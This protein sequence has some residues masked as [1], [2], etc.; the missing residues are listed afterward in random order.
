MEGYEGFSS[1]ILLGKRQRG[2][3]KMRAD[4]PHKMD[5]EGH[6]LALSK[7]SGQSTPCAASAAPRARLPKDARNYLET[8]FE[9]IGLKTLGGRRFDWNR[10]EVR[11]DSLYYLPPA[12]TDF[13]CD[14][15]QK[16]TVS[17]ELKKN[18]FEPSQ[19]LALA[20]HKEDVDSRISLA[21]SD[22]RLTRYLKGETLSILLR[23][24]LPT[25]RLAAALWKAFLLASESSSTES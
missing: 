25:K 16:R 10:V 24:R 8:F 18:R 11:K 15:S 5:G 22:E 13:R 9:E 12:D 20:L 4:F 6:F 1:G 7:K 3:E 21:V 19:P 23:R 2:S 17:G 14:L